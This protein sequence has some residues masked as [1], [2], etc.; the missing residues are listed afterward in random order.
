VINL[1]HISLYLAIGTT[2]SIESKRQ[3]CSIVFAFITYAVF[4][5]VAGKGDGRI[6]SLQV[7]VQ[8]IVVSNPFSASR[9]EYIFSDSLANHLFPAAPMLMR[10]WTTP[11]NKMKPRIK[12]SAKGL[13]LLRIE[14]ACSYFLFSGIPVTVHIH[15]TNTH[16]SYWQKKI[17]A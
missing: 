15:Q 14:H 7:R 12:A 8:G 17:G 10:Q 4:S 6:L 13:E 9:R 5:G 3:V 16:P 11:A 2:D 1:S